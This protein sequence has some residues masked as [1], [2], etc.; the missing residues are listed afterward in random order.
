MDVIEEA[1]TVL[2]INTSS[3]SRVGAASSSMLVFVLR[4]RR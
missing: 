1:R 4:V 2:G 3:M